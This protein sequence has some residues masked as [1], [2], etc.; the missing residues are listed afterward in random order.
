MGV[1]KNLFSTEQKQKSSQQSTQSGTSQS[2]LFDDP[3]FQ[4]ALSGYFGQFSPTNLAGISDPNAYQTG[5]AGNQALATTGLLPAM[6]VANT[7]GTEG[8]T[9]AAI[10]AQM[11]PYISSVVNPTIE[12]QGLQNRQAIST[13]RGNQATRGALGNTTGSEAAYMAGVQ[14]AQQAQIAGLYNQGFDRATQTALQE[15]QAKLGAATTAGSLTGVGT[16]AN[17][18]L[19]GM[20]QQLWQNQ[21][22]PYTLAGQFSQGLTPF[23]QAAGM[24][25]QAEA[26]GT[27]NSTST[28]SPGAGLVGANLL[29]SWLMSDARLK[30]NIT[31]VGATFDGLPIY[32]FNFPG[33]PTQI[34]LMAQDVESRT[35]EAVGE[36]DGLKA[37]DY[38]RATAPAAAMRPYRGEAFNAGGA[39]TDLQPGADGV[40][41]TPPASIGEEQRGGAPASADDGDDFTRKVVT[42]FR[43]FREMR[44]EGGRVGRGRDGGE[45]GVEP[46][47]RPGF[48]VGGAPFWPLA[49]NPYAA[50]S[51]GW[52]APEALTPFSGSILEGSDMAAGPS[53]VPDSWMPV[54][55]KGAAGTQKR[56][57]QKAMGSAL[58]KLG[59]SSDGASQRNYAADGLTSQMASLG[60]FAQ[61]LVQPPRYDDGGSVFPMGAFAGSRWEDLLLQPRYRGGRQDASD[62]GGLAPWEHIYWYNRGTDGLPRVYPGSGG[63]DPQLGPALLPPPPRGSTIGNASPVVSWNR[64]PWMGGP[65]ASWPRSDP[66]GVLD[67]YQGSHGAGTIAAADLPPTLMRDEF[68][69]S[70]T[71]VPRSVTDDPWRAFTS[72]AR[73]LPPGRGEALPTVDWGATP[74]ERAAQGGSDAPQVDGDAVVRG[75]ETAAAARPGPD[76]RDSLGPLGALIPRYDQGLLAGEAPT[77]QQRLGMALL[78]VGP[79]AGAGQALL[80]QYQ[81]RTKERAAEQQAGQL[82][83]QIAHQNAVLAETRRQHDIQAVPDVIRSLEAAGYVK[84]TPEFQEALRK[85][86]TR[87]RTESAG[88]VALAQAGVKEL[89]QRTNAVESGQA[90][91]GLINQIEALATNPNVPQGRLANWELEGRRIASAL[92]PGFNTEGIREG[93]ALRALSNRI[94]L[95]LRQTGDGAGMPGAMSDADRNFL[96]QSAPNLTNT[97]EGNMLL[98]RIMRETEQY[99]LRSN[100]EAIR[101]LRE[102]PAAFGG[103]ADHMGQWMQANPMSAVV[104]THA[105]TREEAARVLGSEG[106]RQGAPAAQRGAGS[107]AADASLPVL[108]PDQAERLP[109]GERF[110]GTDGIARRV[111]YPPAPAATSIGDI[112]PA[113]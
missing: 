24:N 11:S 98:L 92:F 5:A 63:G 4:E 36:V 53:N 38:D 7:V 41:G 72:P 96:Q 17:Q 42:A 90:Q 9:P 79:M 61:G 1:L 77:W 85:I 104:P 54:V 58:T 69:E 78:S 16:Q 49:S 62:G 87:D 45:G 32:S 83:A 21:L 74:A 60:Q 35:P 73:E 18:G 8:L 44:R 95:S 28:S 82:A 6:H 113:P 10:A 103:L 30:D 106:G 19:F 20:G 51:G 37:V 67:P 84:G 88:T 81:E 47:G 40:W 111:P 34:G 93:E 101:Y 48:N 56:G 39:V 33:Q 66:L 15:I 71:D 50:P 91:L 105:A 102:S 57:W 22:A 64:S 3:R 89:T 31:P 100:T 2:N 108:T 29:G 94:T 99:R 26:Q 43:A 52:A 65:E 14:P 110:R 12:A 86:L 107:A 13:L 46:A 70:A 59:S 76:W 68:P 80:A 25:T 23:L 55:E 75:A 27:G 97:R 112:G 109:P